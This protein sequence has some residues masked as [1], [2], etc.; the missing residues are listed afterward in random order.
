MSVPEDLDQIYD[1]EHF[2]FYY[3]YESSDAISNMD[4]ILQMAAIFENV[5]S[6]YIDTLGFSPPV[7]DPDSNIAYMRFMLKTYQAISLVLPIRRIHP[8]LV[9]HVQA[10]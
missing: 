4:Y 1:S 6:F 2:R 3:T 7:N 5:Y 8:S 10:L 9:Q